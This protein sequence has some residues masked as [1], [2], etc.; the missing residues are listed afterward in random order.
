MPRAVPEYVQWKT[1]VPFQLAAQ[2]EERLWNAGKNK[3]QYG[4]RSRL[5]CELLRRWLAGDISLPPETIHD[6]S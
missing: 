6:Q 2:V 5:M 4:A 1:T 3:P